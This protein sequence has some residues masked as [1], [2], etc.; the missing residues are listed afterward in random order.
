MTC[1][2]P[3]P[4][5]PTAGRRGT[6]SSAFR[7]TT[8]SSATDSRL[9]TTVKV[10]TSAPTTSRSS[11]TSL[12]RVDRKGSLRGHQRP[13][14]VMTGRERD[15]DV[16]CRVVATRRWRCTCAQR[17]ARRSRLPRQGRR[18][19]SASPRSKSAASGARA[20]SGSRPRFAMC[21]RRRGK[22]RQVEP[23]SGHSRSPRSSRRTSQRRRRG[24]RR[25]QIDFDPHRPGRRGRGHTTRDGGAPCARSPS[26]NPA[27]SVPAS[28]SS[29]EHGH[30]R[31]GVA[32]R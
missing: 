20:R 15:S 8:V 25:R 5:L 28:R 9:P 18:V 21:A 6:H 1:T 14:R 32:N 2:E 3:A 7:S 16:R 17:L 10:P 26:R 4:G 12:F 11:L 22:R 19:A 31:R 30:R 13:P 23:A 27:G 24:C 29:L